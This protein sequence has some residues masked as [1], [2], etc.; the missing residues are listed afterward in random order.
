LSLCLALCLPLALAGCES[1][2]ASE[3]PVLRFSAI[4]DQ[5]TPFVIAQHAPLMERLCA[6]LHRSCRF[7]PATSYDE[8]VAQIGRGE[9]DVAFLG[10]V[11]FVQARERH[12]A[13]PLA[14]RDI[15]FRFTSVVL[16]RKNATLD[17]LDDL[18]QKP[19][20]FANR[21]STS[22]HVMLRQRLARENVVP[23]RYFS[24]VQYAANHDAA[25]QALAQGRVDGA[26]VNASVYYRRLATGDP[27]AASLRVVWQ[28]PPYVDYV[29]SAREGLPAPQRR[30]QTDAYLDLE[31]AVPADRVALQAESAGGYVPAFAD[32][33]E[34]A[35]GVL[36]ALGQL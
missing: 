12:R 28:T 2:A 6:A 32:D 30:R 14:M 11:G 34:E 8:L 5:G 24:A 29:W 27:V 36:R 21:S 4:P 3:P 13:V 31:A 10:A 19:F 1:P 7:V 17:G 23:E 20:T 35:R 22:G 9:V 26:G 25:M 33:F 18:R 16:V 15:D